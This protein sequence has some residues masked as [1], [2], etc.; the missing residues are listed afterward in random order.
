MESEEALALE[1]QTVVVSEGK[2]TAV[3]PAAEVALPAGAA[4]IDGTGK[5]LLPGLFDT[6]VHLNPSE[7]E[8]HLTLYVANG[9]TTVQSMHGTPEIL[10][11]RD[12]LNSGQFLGPRMVTTGPTTATERVASPEHAA[13]VVQR[14]HEAGY[15]AI[16]MYGDG[17]RSL[18]A[19]S[20]RAVLDTAHGLGMRVVGHAPRNHPFDLVLDGGETGGQDSIDH[21]E[22]IV[23]TDTGI[24]E[25]MGPLVNSQFGG[26]GEG[27]DVDQV[28]GS[29]EEIRA[30]LMPA[31]AALTAKV[32]AADLAITPTLV[33]FETIW[34]QTTPQYE[35]LMQAE[36]MRYISAMLRVSW[37]PALNRYRNGGWQGRLEE[38]DPILKRSL[39][40][41]KV[42][43]KSFHDAG[44]RIM[45]GTDAPLTFVY[46]GFATHRE[47]ELFV[48]AG[49]TPHEALRAATVVP[50]AELGL[51]DSGT[52]AVGQRA[53]LL[54]LDA[55]PRSDIRNTRKIHGVV[56]AGRWHPI[57]ALELRLEALVALYAP[58]LEPMEAL[59]E[60]YASGDAAQIATAYRALDNPRPVV[61]QAV[62]T[63]VNRLGY[64]HLGAD[65]V[66]T[67]IE[68]FRINT[69]LFPEAFNAW[70]SLGEAYMTQGETEKAKE[71]YRKS[72]ELNPENSNAERMIERME[73]SS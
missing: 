30:R 71:S 59:G 19:E 17:N 70:D 67:A 25:V 7:H 66:E 13:E 10:E 23:Y 22:E 11:T 41:Q 28:P 40:L 38:M 43:V 35:Q 29:F 2:I 64:Q 45:A 42:L 8:A 31:V 27:G 55:D 24:L 46:P 72:L 53:D 65:D 44:V 57:D 47:L 62:E 34:K 33:A 63:V 49:L 18:S 6:H 26:G 50:A 4:V 12:R 51:T 37:G 56:A 54:L 60:A 3:G 20:Y 32:K 14:Q 52:V 48:E 16:K 1:D 73:G 58:G 69:E 61:A 21:M 15:D 36:E 68:V 9:V 5:F 39:E